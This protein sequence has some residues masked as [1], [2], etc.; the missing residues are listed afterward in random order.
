MTERAVEPHD[1][2]VCLYD[3]YG[4]SLYRYALML[5]TDHAA[6]EDAVHE[7]FTSMLRSGATARLEADERYLRRA[8]RNECF[9]MLKQRSKR[10]QIQ[11]EPDA[12][13]ERIASADSKPDERLA[14]ERGIRLLTPEQREAVHLH[15]FNG[16]TFKEVAEISGESLNTVAARYRYALAKLRKLIEG[17]KGAHAQHSR[18]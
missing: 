11:G 16:L 8:I 12:M 1:T 4:P 3:R 18:R 5:L 2:V 7:V 15:V 17:V 9:S 6:A 13:L 14:L 10:R